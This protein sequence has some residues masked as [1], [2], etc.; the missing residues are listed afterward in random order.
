MSLDV[1]ALAGALVRLEPL[2]ESHIADLADSAA[3]RRTYR[4][5]AVPNGPTATA[6]YVHRLVAADAAGDT[7]SFAQVRPVDARVLGVT[8]FLNL[9]TRPEDSLPYAV[10]IGR[11]WLAG[12]AQRTGINT[13]TKLLLLAHAFETWNVARVD[14]KTDARNTQARTALARLGT[15]FEGILRRWQPSQVAGEEDHLRDTAIYSILRPEWPTT[16]D[17]LTARLP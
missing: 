14:F 2:A 9:R 5:I 4:Y 3:D 16:R 1:P 6:N 11:T 13:E 10:E 17:A 8:R 7:F 12:D 15:K